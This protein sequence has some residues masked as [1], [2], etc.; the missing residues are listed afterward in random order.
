MMIMTIV[1]FGLY[2]LI[3]I[4]KIFR[5]FLHWTQSLT[6]VGAFSM[7]IVRILIGFDLGGSEGRK[8]EIL[9]QDPDSSSWM[10]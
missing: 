4:M 3:L 1:E 9:L 5:H 2:W 10:I 8:T 7:M 6:L